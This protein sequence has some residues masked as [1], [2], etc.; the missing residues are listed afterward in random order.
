MEGFELIDSVRVPGE[1]L[2]LGLYKRGAEFS[3]RIN[4]TELMDSVV[5]ESEDALSNL[6]CDELAGVASP[7]VLIGGLG[8]G[9]TL[10]AALKRLGPGA[11][12]EIVELLGAVIAWNRGPL[13]HLAAHPLKDARVTVREADV[14]RVL[15]TEEEAYDAVLLDVDNGPEGL[16]RDSNNWLYSEDGLAAAF[17]AL[18]PGGILAVWSSGPDKAFR[19]RLLKLGFTVRE[20]R[21]PVEA[22]RPDTHHIIWIA[23]RP[24]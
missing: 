18:R 17:T 5:H 2:R 11:T 20:E 12:V 14:A 13:G 1:G 15:Q 3:L 6:A 16:V 23:K 24:A 4:N 9:Y 19:M 8:M 10:A 22:S 21:T 7:A